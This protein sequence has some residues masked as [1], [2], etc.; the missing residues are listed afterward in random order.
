VLAVLSRSPERVFWIVPLDQE[1]Y[2]GVTVARGLIRPMYCL[3][4][5]FLPWYQWTGRAF[6][7]NLYMGTWVLGVTDQDLFAE[8]SENAR[9]VVHFGPSPRV[10]ILDFRGA[11]P[12]TRWYLIETIGT[13]PKRGWVPQS[14]FEIQ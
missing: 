7:R 11:D 10:K 6:A 2:W 3:E 8:P 5:D 12:Q 1:R 4:C 14:V 9:V 13:N